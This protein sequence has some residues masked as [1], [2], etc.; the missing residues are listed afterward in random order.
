MTHVSTI[1]KTH[2]SNHIFPLLSLSFQ[3][4]ICSHYHMWWTIAT[5]R[6][7]LIKLETNNM[8]CLLI[9]LTSVCVCACL[10][11]CVCVCDV[12]FWLLLLYLSC[13]QWSS[14][15]WF[16]RIDLYFFSACRRVGLHRYK[17]QKILIGPAVQ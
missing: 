12:T 5:R 14:L 9:E 3:S 15:W 8:S 16:I 7:F 13:P 2:K 4:F 6:S 10:R 17:L 1:V 11:V